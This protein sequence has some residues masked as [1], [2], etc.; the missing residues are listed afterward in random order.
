VAQEQ[1]DRGVSTI[2]RDEIAQLRGDVGWN[3]R[4]AVVDDEG[5]LIEGELGDSGAATRGLER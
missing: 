5:R 4:T 2:G 1:A 3:R